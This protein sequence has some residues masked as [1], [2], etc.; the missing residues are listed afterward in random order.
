MKKLSNIMTKVPLLLQILALDPSWHCRLTGACPQGSCKPSLTNNHEYYSLVLWLSPFSWNFQT[1]WP[2]Q[3]MSTES[4]SFRIFWIKGLFIGGYDEEKN[5]IKSKGKK[6]F[7]LKE[8]LVCNPFEF[9]FWPF[10]CDSIPS[11]DISQL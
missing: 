7:S 9:Y 1:R 8:T 6:R 4:N 11:L 5:L 3:E 2:H 10:Y